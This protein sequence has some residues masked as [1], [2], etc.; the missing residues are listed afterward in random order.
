MPSKK[1]EWKLGSIFFFIKKYS[2]FKIKYL[3]DRDIILAALRDI[4]I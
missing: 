3:K 1:L 2:F 4:L